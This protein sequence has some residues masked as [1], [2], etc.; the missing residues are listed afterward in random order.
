MA[1]ISGAFERQFI[2]AI[3]TLQTGSRGTIVLLY[4]VQSVKLEFSP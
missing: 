2:S 3:Q 4:S 1:E